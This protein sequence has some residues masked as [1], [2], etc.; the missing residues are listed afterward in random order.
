MS[1]KNV[2]K[3]SA[4]EKHQ[5]ESA[6]KSDSKLS[7]AQI[8][9]ISRLGDKYWRMNHLYKIRNQ[10]GKVVV[11]KFNELQQ[12]LWDD[13]WFFNVLLK[14][15]QFGG[16][17]WICIYFLDDVL[18]TKGLEA[19]IIAHRR[20]DA[21]KIFRRKIRFPY[22]NLPEGL[23]SAVPLER[24]TT[25]ELVFGNGSSIYVTTSARSGTVQRLHISEYGKI[26][27]KMPEKA[28]EIKTGALNAVHPGGHIWIESTA[29]G[30]FGDF[31]DRCQTARNLK[32]AGKKLSRIQ[33][34]F[35]FFPWFWDS[36][37]QLPTNEAALIEIRPEMA[38]YFA[39][40]E[41]K[42]TDIHGNPLHLSHEQRA[43]Y[44]LKYDD[45]GDDEMFREYPS[46]YDEAFNAAVK[47]G[48]FSDQMAAMRRE[49]RIGRVPWDPN[50]PVDT[51]WDIGMDAY[52]V[53]IYHQ[54]YM[55]ENRVI[56]LDWDSGDAVEEYCRLIQ[57]KPYTY[58][59]H[60]LPHD[61]RVRDWGGTG[62]SRVDT[63]R[64]LLPGHRI[65]LAPGPQEVNRDTGIQMT[66]RLL[67]TTFI[68][69]TKCDK[70]VRMLEGY[71]RVPDEKHGGFKPYPVEDECCHFAD[72][73]R[74]RA[75]TFKYRAQT[76]KK[77][78]R[79]RRNAAVV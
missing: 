31:F 34:E 70:L 20:E 66:R 59:T 21:E 50:L 37:N 11:F 24:D 35:H 71:R 53:I 40:I 13:H 44:Q 15:R 74:I 38:K 36:K 60:W 42:S 10:D 39:E 46:T 33:Y 16:T 9:V 18:F 5:A 4:T 41:A 3:R 57:T 63:M 7:R 56:D 62:K 79:R 69:E 26:C 2:K 78:K 72:A 49:K 48:Y 17:T 67:A 8:E 73:M 47:G 12:K 54:R 77:P 1:D 61:G 22:D 14:A 51:T 76:G 55:Q 52:T 58:G 64:K 29:E 6:K 45:Q 28:L 30:R 43:W 27:A 23:K 19:G 75:I 65:Q 25:S 68:D 32:L